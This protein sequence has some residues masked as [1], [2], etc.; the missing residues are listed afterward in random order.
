[1]KILSSVLFTLALLIGV[2]FTAQVHAQAAGCSTSGGYNPNTGMSCNGSTVVPLGCSSTAGFSTVN[3]TPCNGSTVVANSYNG[4]M[5]NSNT[6]LNGCSSTAGF[7]T[8]T[9]YACNTAINGIIYA[10]PTVGT[11]N[12]GLPG[13]TT[14]TPTSPGLPTTG[15]GNN[16][17]VN[18]LLLTSAAI[19]TVVAFRSVLAYSRN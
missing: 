2:G 19:V 18:I 16:L 8:T 4:T 6:Y 1:M 11:V 15:A 9:G 10:G 3:N 14:I 5:V 12:I 7:S 13:V 17:I